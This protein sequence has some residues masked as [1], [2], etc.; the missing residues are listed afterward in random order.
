MKSEEKI[1]NLVIDPPLQLE[2]GEYGFS[3]YQIVFGSNPQLPSIL[4]D[5]PSA[6]LP[7]MEKARY[8]Q[9]I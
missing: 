6:F 1:E 5:K 3:P 7:D 8:L 2:R 4:T 9:T